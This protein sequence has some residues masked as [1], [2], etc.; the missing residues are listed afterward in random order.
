MNNKLLTI[1]IASYNIERFIRDTVGSLIV[2]NDDLK[3]MEI[4]IVD[5]GS[6]D[7]TNKIAHEL[8]SRFPESIIVIDKENTSNVSSTVVDCTKKKI[9]VLRQGSIIIK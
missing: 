4:I 8:S 5:D 9:K 2:N 1:S 3:K 7:N 6:K